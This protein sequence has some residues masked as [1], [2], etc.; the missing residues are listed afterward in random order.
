MA[1]LDDT[2]GALGNFFLDLE[3]EELSALQGLPGEIVDHRGDL[4][5]AMLVRKALGAVILAL[6]KR[7]AGESCGVFDVGARSATTRDQAFLGNLLNR[8]FDGDFGNAIELAE[9]N[10]GG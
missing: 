7:F 10:D 5:A 8:S 2:D 1:S 4:L 3:F 9:L 6:E